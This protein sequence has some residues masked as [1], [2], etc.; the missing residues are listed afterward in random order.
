MRG[1]TEPTS[2]R[3]WRPALHASVGY[4][5][6]GF[7]MPAF[8]PSTRPV[9][10]LRLIGHAGL[11]RC[12]RPADNQSASPDASTG[13]PYPVQHVGCGLRRSSFPASR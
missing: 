3:L 8:H 7:V 1:P 5:G 12:N 2:R 9:P 6:D 4:E 10:G 11:P 13:G